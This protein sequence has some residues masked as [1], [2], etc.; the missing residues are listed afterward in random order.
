MALETYYVP[1]AQEAV[2]LLEGERILDLG[3]GPGF[4]PVEIARRAPRVEVEGIDLSRRLVESARRNASA[5]GVADRVRFEEGDA[6]RLRWPDESFDMVVSTGMVHAL[7]EPVRVF[8]E[9]FRV[10]KTGG[11]ALLYD[12]A[13]VSS[14]IDEQAWKASF[15]PGEWILFLLFRIFAK[16]NPGRE[17]TRQEMAGMIEEAGFRSYEI[18]VKDKETRVRMTKTEMTALWRTR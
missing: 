10:L 3:T 5:A 9:C 18:R 14:R 4:L 16:I 11:T 15:T 6:S 1:V 12:P 17:Y 8:E 13:R 2:G 7:K